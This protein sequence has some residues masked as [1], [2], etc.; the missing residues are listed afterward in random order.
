[1][2]W[3]L[4]ICSCVLLAAC[5]H[6]PDKKFVGE[7]RSGCSIDVCT[8]TLLKADHTFSVKHDEKDSTVAYSGTWRVEGDRLIT[9]V[10]A[11]DEMLQHIMGKNFRITVSDF[12]RDS[13]RATLMD[14]HGRSDIWKRLH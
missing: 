13:F 11:A 6:A 7:W 8:I 2:G 10:T 9:H 4:I 3:L 12:H 1:M 14:E 5:Y